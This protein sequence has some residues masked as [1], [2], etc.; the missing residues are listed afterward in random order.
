[1]GPFIA[2]FDWCDD[3]DTRSQTKETSMDTVLAALL[4]KNSAGT[5]VAKT[6]DTP[7]K[8]PATSRK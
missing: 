5:P 6:S 1:M 8:K 2:L 4:R 7:P 3:Y